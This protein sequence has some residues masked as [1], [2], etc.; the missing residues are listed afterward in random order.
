MRSVFD[1]LRVSELFQGDKRKAVLSLA[2]II[3]GESPEAVYGASYSILHRGMMEYIREKA[4][5]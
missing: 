5:K 4:T 2:R 3:K 1:I